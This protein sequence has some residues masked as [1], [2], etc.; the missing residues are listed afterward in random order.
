M[1]L[2]VTVGFDA[3]LPVRA[4]ANLK[5]THIYLLRAST[6]GEGDEKSAA[7]V[8]HLIKVL[9]RGEER[10]IDLR[11]LATGLRQLAEVDFDAVALAGG[12]R[13]LVLL[14]FVAAVLKKA[15]VYIVPEY[16]YDA[17]DATGLAAV[18]YLYPLSKAKLRV[19]AKLTDGVEV[20]QLA[21]ELGLD[22]STVYRHLDALTE[23]G[24]VTAE[25][26]RGRRYRV[27]QLTVT[28]AAIMARL[29]P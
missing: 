23:A 12:P 16:S 25:G 27:D 20:D 22:T 11:D 9:G 10:V 15:R 7:A 21:R 29:N 24:L 8:R 18:A 5:A 2:A 14:A 3:D 6:G 28:I 19:L 4:L 26:K 17:I 13:A 1:K